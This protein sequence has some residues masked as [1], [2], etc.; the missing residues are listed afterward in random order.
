MALAN[1]SVV[2]RRSS[3][4][5]NPQDLAAIPLVIGPSSKG[6]VNV[7]QTFMSLQQ[8][9]DG[10]GD[11]PGPELAG[12][13]LGVAGGPVYFV[14]S[15][16]TTAGSSGS[17]T[18]T[19]PSDAVGTATVFPGSLVAAGAD[20]DGDL[21]F[22]EKNTAVTA[23]I[24]FAVGGAL[25]LAVVG[26]AVT[27]TVTNTTTGAQAASFFSSDGG[28]GSVAARALFDCVAL[29][30]ATSVC[31]QNLAATNCINGRMTITPLQQG[32]SVEVL[33]PS[34][35]NQSFAGSYNAGTK[36]I[37]LSL[38]TDAKKKPTTTA[39]LAKTT[40][41]TGL[42]ALATAN[43]GVFSVSLPGTGANAPGAKAQTTLL[44]GSTGAMA[45]ST[46]AANDGYLVSCKVTRAGTVGGA[47]KPA[48]SW[49]ADNV[50][51]SGEVLIPD[52]GVVALKDTYL[53]TGLAVTFSG[54]L[55]VGDSFSFTTVK[56]QSSLTDI[57]AA[58]D[59]ALADTSRQWGFV[60]CSEALTR[61]NVVSL[62]S[63]L[64]SVWTKRFAR[65]KL[66]VRDI[67]EGVPNET[68]QQWAD[69]V[70]NDF[71]G[72]V[73]GSNA[74]TEAGGL[75]DVTAAPVKHISPLSLRTFRRHGV[76]ATAPRR[77]S[78]PVHEDLGATKS[79]P[80]RNILAIYHDEAINPQ[81]DAQRFQ[82]LRTYDARPGQFYITGS[83]TMADSSNVAYALEQWTATSLSLARIAKAA[84][85]P[86][87]R[88][89]LQAIGA[90]EAGTG[91]PEG[92]LTVPEATVIE[93][94]VGAQMLKFLFQ[95][96][97]D[98]KVSASPYADGEKPAEVVR[99]NNFL[100]DRTVSMEL[101][102]RPKGVA[103]LIKIGV[104]TKLGS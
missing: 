12:A 92:A 30:A 78:I 71:A 33:V 39:S 77:A 49:T 20:T 19:D 10:A 5:P 102:W 97:T 84:A 27:F 18:K 25:G 85:F 101:A 57:Q 75:V 74:A 65:G 22:T 48:M 99:T 35:A 70:S 72:F 40:A 83:P 55:V 15:A 41:V 89:S 50:L 79:G 80:A 98:G 82:T 67:A 69:A 91:A 103:E 44:F 53:D 38:A 76:W 66:S 104:N 1:I 42:D 32:V 100:V 94:A 61:A 36:K 7:P 28:A 11:G 16:K 81:L 34:T 4:A 13:I 46:G 3:V 93:S 68:R 43:P 26:N 9:Q 24:Q 95:A 31:N 6:T 96:K 73:S 62:D 51:Y 60:T 45:V 54:A 56:P 59:G 37:S 29:G 2:L 47:T 88:D 14:P 63:K 17:V 8:I 90:P 58:L 87:L 23:T 86:Y 52:S 21:L 64:Q